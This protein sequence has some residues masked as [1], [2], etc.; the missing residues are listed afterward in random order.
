MYGCV[1]REPRVQRPLL[2][3]TVKKS[4]FEVVPQTLTRYERAGVI[5]QKLLLDLLIISICSDNENGSP[6]W[7]SKVYLFIYANTY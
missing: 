6:I 7:S 3:T 1:G 5:D 2:I 4:F